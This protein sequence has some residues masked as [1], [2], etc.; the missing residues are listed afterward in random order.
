MCIICSKCFIQ[1]YKINEQQKFKGDCLTLCGRVIEIPQYIHITFNNITT[2]DCSYSN[3]TKLPKSF[4]NLTKLHCSFSNII[5]IPDTYVNL[6]ELDC[7]R[8]VG[9]DD[10]LLP[11]TFIN[12]IYLRLRNSKT[13]TI[14]NTYI[15]LTELDCSFCPNLTTLPDTFINLTTLECSFCVNLTYLPNTFINL[16]ILRCDWCTNLLKLP[17]TLINLLWID[18][19][20]CSLL[21]AENNKM[22]GYTEFMDS[23]G[24]IKYSWNTHSKAI[25]VW[26]NGCKWLNHPDTDYKFNIPNIKFLQKWFRKNIKFWIFKR[27]IKSEECVKWLYNPNRI[28]GK[29]SKSNIIRSIMSLQSLVT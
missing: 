2:L 12:L 19:T 20:G 10:V 16:E 11:N 15:N 6:T 14:P 5:E 25:S 27:W 4:S 8:C 29:I 21:V 24:F 23:Q 28:G 7:S 13:T 3:I 17:A 18:C 1:N 26:S 9:A 22:F